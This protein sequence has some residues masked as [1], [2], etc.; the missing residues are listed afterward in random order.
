MNTFTLKNWFNKRRHVNNDQHAVINNQL[1]LTSRLSEVQ[2]PVHLPWIET[3]SVSTVSPLD[4]ET[5]DDLKREASF[6][7]ATLRAAKQAIQQLQQ[8]SIAY[9]RPSD[10][11]AEMLKPDS[12]MSRIK[13][14]LLTEQ[15]R[16]KSIEQ[17]KK[18]REVSKF[19]KQVQVQKEIEK[20]KAK[21]QAIQSVQTARL[22]HKQ[23]GELFDAAGEEE[24]STIH[25]VNEQ[26]KSTKKEI[27]N[28][29]STNKGRQVRES[30]FGFGGKK[31]GKKQNDK[32]STNKGG[33]FNQ[34]ENRSLPTGFKRDKPGMSRKERA[35]TF[36]QGKGSNKR[37]STEGKSIRFASRPGKSKR[38]QS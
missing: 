33:K 32:E 11:Y 20:T 7:N 17:R 19:S 18:S 12:Q 3:L 36:K 22:R 35:N 1:A 6:Y 38:Q 37:K 31:S 27:E 30:K 23:S 34:Q 4:V 24:V 25:A 29:R 15:Q 2:L 13:N 14:S 8:N 21:K 9:Q 28:K 5:T 26:L 10:Y 16:I